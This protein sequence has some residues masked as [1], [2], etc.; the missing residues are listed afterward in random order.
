MRAIWYPARISGVA[1]AKTPSGAVASELAKEGKK[2][3]TFLEAEVDLGIGRSSL[4]CS[5]GRPG[6]SSYRPNAVIELSPSTTLSVSR[7]D[8]PL[9]I[10][11]DRCTMLD[12]GWR[13][14]CIQGEMILP[15][16]HGAESNST[17]PLRPRLKLPT[18][19]TL[20]MHGCSADMQ[21]SWPRFVLRPFP[22]SAPRA[23]RLLQDATRRRYPKCE[24][25]QWV[26]SLPHR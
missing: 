19:T 9:T 20:S 16:P 11:F 13:L 22:R 2:K 1:T 3:T 24:R 12:V 18:L 26:C 6:V 10:R 15:Y 14:Q 4:M 7:N 17:P 25:K 8:R 21:I 5:V 23:S